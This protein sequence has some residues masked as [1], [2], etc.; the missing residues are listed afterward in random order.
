MRADELKPEQATVVDCDTNDVD[1][2]GFQR[3]SSA[4]GLLHTGIAG[5]FTNL[6]LRS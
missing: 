3:S 6:R 5:G 4:S 2:Q 1:L